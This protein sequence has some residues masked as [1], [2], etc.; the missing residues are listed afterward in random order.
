VSD[1]PFADRLAARVVALESVLCV[2]LDPRA[3]PDDCRRGLRADRAGQARAVERYCLGLVE[4]VEPYAAAVKPQVALFEVLGG[5]GLTALDRVCAAA[6]AAG[7]LVI[8]DGKRGDIDSTA[9]AYAAAWLA[10]RLGEEAPVG[11]ALT[12]SPYLGGDATA[13]FLAACDR[14]GAGLYVLT[15]TSNPGAADLQELPL[16]GGG[17]VWER[18]AAQVAGWGAG[19]IGAAGLASV[20]AVVGLTAPEAVRRARAAMPAAPLLL[21]GLGAQGGAPVD[22]SAAFVPHPAGG[23]VASAR[24]IIEA[25]QGAAGPWREAVG[26][27]ARSSRDALR[28]LAF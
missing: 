20:G 15:R 1:V 9:A 7:L 25:W 27:A 4:A 18:V 19:R 16:A 11:D 23:L 22:A 5:Y 12:V 10:P 3:V 14:H 28:P 17:S 24:A 26:S 6:R 13:P 8:V 21:P 2:G